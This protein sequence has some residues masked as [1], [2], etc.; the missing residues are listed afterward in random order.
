VF[1]VATDVTASGIRGIII[2]VPS[3]RHLSS[4][5]CCPLYLYG[6]GN[7]TS[8]STAAGLALGVT[9]IH[10]PLCY[11]KVEITLEGNW[12]MTPQNWKS[13]TGPVT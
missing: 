6:L 9:G 7:P 11:G 13:Q 3:L 4:S 8:S 5:G 1:L 12:L 10:K 2:G